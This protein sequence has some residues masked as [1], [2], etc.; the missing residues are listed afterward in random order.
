MRGSDGK[1]RSR[2][3]RG[4]FTLVGEQTAKGERTDRFET[5]EGMTYSI[6]LDPGRALTRIDIVLELQKQRLAEDKEIGK[7]I[8][9]RTKTT[10]RWNAAKRKYEKSGS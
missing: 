8:V 10:Y 1:A 2:R 7:P 9:T 6:R 5:R 3:R 4:R